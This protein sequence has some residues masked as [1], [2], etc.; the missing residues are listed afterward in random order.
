[1][2]TLKTGLIGLVLGAGVAFGTAMVGSEEASAAACCS[3]CEPA[4]EECVDGCYGDSS[5]ELW[6]SRAGLSCRRTCDSSC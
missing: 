3:S 5:C 4:Y 6:C 2:K 1:M